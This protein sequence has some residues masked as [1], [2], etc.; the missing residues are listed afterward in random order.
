MNNF[1]SPINCQPLLYELKYDDE[2]ITE[3]QNQY[4]KNVGDDYGGELDDVLNENDIEL[5]EIL[6]YAREELE[7]LQTVVFRQEMEASKELRTQFENC[8]EIYYETKYRVS[9][10]YENT[11]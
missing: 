2:T 3:K 4:I 10:F 11:I 5:T 6:K 9:I 8:M 1:K 7:Y